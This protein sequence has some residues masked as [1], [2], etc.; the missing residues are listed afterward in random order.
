MSGNNKAFVRKPFDRNKFMQLL[1]IGKQQ[2]GW[3]DEFYRG[4]WLPQRGATKDEN[5]R[6]SATTLSNSQLFSALE[7][8]KALGFKVK[9]KR[10][11]N[12]AQPAARP[13]ADDAQSKKIRALWLELH[14]CGAVRDPSEAALAA[15]VKRQHGVE[16]LQWLSTDQASK[17]I[18][19]L[20]KWRQRL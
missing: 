12:G 6:Y 9:P 8:M 4:I 17:V 10:T 14:A 15:F 1:A 3:D 2:L 13:L 16:A 20:K 18:E 7:A 5:G 11:R 19:A